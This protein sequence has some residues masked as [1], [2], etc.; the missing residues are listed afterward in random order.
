[1]N[2]RFSA[3]VVYNNY[4]WPQAATAEQRQAIEEA[5]QAVLDARVKYP[6]SSLA[7]LYDR[8]MPSDLVEA[9][10]KLDAAV[11]A[12]F[13]KKKF[14][15]D[16]N[17]VGLPVRAL[18]A[19]FARDDSSPG[20]PIERGDL[21]IRDAGIAEAHGQ[22]RVSSHPIPGWGAQRETARSAPPYRAAF[23]WPIS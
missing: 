20:T 16:T 4:P 7:D 3:E 18:P 14:P 10:Q 8:N 23:A 6:V 12:A 22:R 19:D 17:Y 2:Y 5:A 11:D 13:S 1:M 21:P 15:S 9:Q